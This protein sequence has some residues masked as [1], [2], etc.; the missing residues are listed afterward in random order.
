MAVT[1]KPGDLVSRRNAYRRSMPTLSSVSAAS[2]AVTCSFFTVGLPKR[3]KHFD[4]GRQ[5]HFD[6][7][8]HF[9]TV[10]QIQDAM[11]E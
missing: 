5:F 7:A 1:A 2:T 8:I 4:V 10:K 6:F 9:G 11:D 3:S